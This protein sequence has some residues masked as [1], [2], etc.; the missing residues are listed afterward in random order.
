MRE[1][2]H[3]GMV[4]R[5]LPRRLRFDWRSAAVGGLAAFALM[6]VG[7][8][9]P[10]HQHVS[11]LERR[12][13]ALTQVV[14]RLDES[15]DAAAAASGLLA[16][17]TEQAARVEAAE[18]AVARMAAL[19][20]RT[21]AAAAGVERATE[22]LGSL[23]DVSDTI[24]AQAAGME[25]AREQLDRLVLLK[26]GLLSGTTDL[27]AARDTLVGLEDLAGWAGESA[28]VVVE[29]RKFVVDLMLLQPAADRARQALEPIVELVKLGRRSDL[30]RP[31]AP[32]EG[33]TTASAERPA[34]AG[35]T[36]TDTK[37]ETTGERPVPKAAARPRRGVN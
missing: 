30:E 17:L 25:M 29:L 18:A 22:A 2:L 1:K 33:T 20:D 36:A 12:I 14:I 31:R 9:R 11:A 7:M 24:V 27:D 35:D 4:D 8:V 3:L 15:R 5:L 16:T 6:H 10:A 23:A 37:A 26:D 19:H 13:D 28:A 32:A 21:V 34:P